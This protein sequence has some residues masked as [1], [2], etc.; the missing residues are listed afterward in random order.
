LKIFSMK[1]FE[2][3]FFKAFS[4]NAKDQRMMERSNFWI[5]NELYCESISKSI[6]VINL[7]KSSLGENWPVAGRLSSNNSTSGG[8]SDVSI[9]YVVH[10]QPLSL[11]RF[12]IH[13]VRTNFLIFWISLK[14]ESIELLSSPNWSFGETELFISIK[15]NHF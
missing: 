4:I 1:F 3:H 5:R 13:E 8:N 12:F 14:C 11:D 6:F 10:K 9:K 2:K 7:Q 15:S